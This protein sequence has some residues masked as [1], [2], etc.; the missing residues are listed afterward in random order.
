MRLDRLSVAGE[1]NQVER[2]LKRKGQSQAT[3]KV[4]YYEDNRHQ[5]VS[6]LKQ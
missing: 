6:K 2:T 4:N 5:K 3:I 1:D